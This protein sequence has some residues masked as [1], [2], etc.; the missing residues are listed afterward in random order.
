MKKVLPII[1]VIILV[2]A[3]AGG[4]YAYHTHT[5]KN[6]RDE[7]LAEQEQKDL[8]Q[9]RINEIQK[10]LDNS[11]EEK[12]TLSDKIDALLDSI[13]KDVY[14]F[15][16]AE[17]MNEIAE[18]GE[19]ATVEYRYTNVGTI[20]ATK[21][22]DM[23][24][25]DTKLPFSKKTV[26]MT[27]DGI[28]KIGV[29]VT[30]ITVTSDEGTKTITVTMPQAK[31]L[32]NELDEKSAVVYDE[33]SEIFNKVTLEDGSELRTQIKEKAEQN[34]KK[35]GVYEQA[36]K[37]AESIIRCMMDAIPQLKETYTVVFK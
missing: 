13:T 4:A 23:K 31:L 24:W 29:D 36:R 14:V 30:K 33:S 19:L 22:L 2:L 17:L 20:D 37:N 32:S 27:M 8:L 12:K 21:A 35:N 1:I 5:I 28:I 3:L 6:I 16:S 18:I 26:V 25:F 15:D 11:E 7:V 34:A 9:Q 10:K